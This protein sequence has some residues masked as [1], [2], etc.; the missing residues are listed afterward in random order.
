M[1]AKRSSEFI[2][3]W[4]AATFDMSGPD[5][6]YVGWCAS[7][8]ATLQW[9]QASA[10][11]VGTVVGNALGLRGSVTGRVEGIAGKIERPF[12]LSLGS[13]A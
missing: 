13:L 12:C 4:R 6:R 1:F 3:G 8:R 7:G 10:C 11:G 2:F 5:L 9:K